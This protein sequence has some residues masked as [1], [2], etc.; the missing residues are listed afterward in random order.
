M[1]RILGLVLVTVLAAAACAE[2]F[3][4][5]PGDAGSVGIPRGTA[6]ATPELPPVAT[7]TRTPAVVDV[8]DLPEEGDEVLP[9]RVLGWIE[10]GGSVVCRAGSCYV[11]LRDPRDPRRYVTLEVAVDAGGAPNTM[12]PLGSDF[13]DADLVVTTADGSTLRSGDHA[14]VTGTW[15]P[16]G[17]TLVAESI[18]RGA[19]PK[20]KIVETTIARLKSKKAGTLVRV[21]GRLDTPFLLSCYGGTCNL[22][23]AS[24][25]KPLRIEVRLGRK[26]EARPN[27]MWPLK[28]NFRAG[29]LRVI[30]AKKRTTRAGDRVVVEGWLVKTDDGTPYLDPVV[31]ITRRGS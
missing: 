23:L 15:M 8:A 10:P 24:A 1:R 4:P 19:A 7:P 27:T 17:D 21:S 9:V 12:H 20:I 6:S 18:E 14:W 26:G 25:A 30:D 22:Y 11:D 2:A 13:T 3:E 16:D 31:K 29:S 28:D 5:P